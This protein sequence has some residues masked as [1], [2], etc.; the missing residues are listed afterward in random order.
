MAT[1]VDGLISGLDT[2]S[3]IQQLMQIEATPQTRLK[4]TLTNQQSALSSLQSI[5]TKM[6]NLQAAAETLQNST[7]WGAAK[8]TS[9]SPGVTVTAAPGALAGSTTFSV[10]QVAA[11]QS[12]VSSSTFGSL[13]DTTAITDTAFEI[14]R[15]TGTGA[16]TVTVNTPADGSLQSLV[17]AINSTDGAGVRAAAV[18]VSAGQYRLQ[19]P[20]TDTGTA[21][22]FTLTGAG[23]AP[24]AN[25]P[26]TEVTAAKDAVLHVGDPSLGFDITSSSNVV[27]G[28][29][30]GVTVKVSSPATSVT[31]SVTQD[32]QAITS[33][34]QAFVDAANSALVGIGSVSSSGVVGADG[35][36]SGVGALAGDGLM[37][38]LTSQILSKVT[39]GVGGT[40]LSTVGIGVNKDG[41]ITL[42]QAKLTTAL[43]ADPSGTMARFT[44]ATTAG[45]GLADVMQSLAKDSSSSTG[46]IAS[47]IEGRQSTIKDL[48]SR[49]AD[50]D[51]RLSDR[52]AALQRQYSALEVALGKLKSQSTWLAGQINSM[53]NNSGSG[54]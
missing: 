35:T 16:S 33:A 39:A 36:R 34:V 26:L 8:A 13:S 11:A 21:N 53:S 12:F 14:H 42:D 2:T 40:S 5:N 19:L 18:Q 47:A 41:I 54:S 37:R 46:T 4:T 17:N 51:V 28:V 15:G 22:A 25:L 31:V 43:T 29:I 24:L 44:T 1:T 32:Q 27:E 9:S 23:G 6:A 38:Q 48:T 50:W 7:T 10:T 20:S 45:T 49:I 3:I 52:Q 30:P